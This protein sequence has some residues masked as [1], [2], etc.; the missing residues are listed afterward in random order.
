MA[1]QPTNEPKIEEVDSDD[2]DKQTNPTGKQLNRA[3]KKSRKAIAKLGLKP[4]DKCGVQSKIIRITI[5]KQKNILFVIS[6]PD[7]WRTADG[8]SYAVFGE[9]RIEDLT[10]STNAL[11]SMGMGGGLSQMAQAAAAAV[12]QGG[13]QGALEGEPSSGE[14]STGD[15]PSSGES[16]SGGGKTSS[17]SPKRSEKESS[18]SGGS[19]TSG[20]QVEEKDVELVVTQVGCD[21]EKAIAAL[22][23]NKNDIVEAIMS[24]NM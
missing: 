16:K 11:R 19:P 8:G 5:K 18:K 23:A 4:L 10:Q 12:G 3:E 7:V 6:N 20:V 14:T 13:G 15:L 1:A 9:A 17:K 22:K 24:F 21:R 2:S